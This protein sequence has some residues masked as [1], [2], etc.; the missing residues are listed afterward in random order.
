MFF[1]GILSSVFRSDHLPHNCWSVMNGLCVACSHWFT[2]LLRWES[3]LKSLKH[4]RLHGLN[5]SGPSL[6]ISDLINAAVRALLVDRL[7]EG[8]ER[9]GAPK[10]YDYELFSCEIFQEKNTWQHVQLNSTY[11]AFLSLFDSGNARRVVD[12]CSSR[13]TS[14]K[15]AT[16]HT[17][18]RTSAVVPSKGSSAI[19]S[20]DR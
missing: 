6:Q 14:P 3:F 2:P 1:L 5:P 9:T 11:G 15:P 16:D 4:I 8:L 12:W 20:L 10:I 18:A 17:S 7:T 13:I 19:L